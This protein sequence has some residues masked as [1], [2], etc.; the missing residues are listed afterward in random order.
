LPF[1]KTSFSE[2]RNQLY[3]SMLR[4]IAGYGCFTA[5]FQGARRTRGIQRCLSFKGREGEPLAR[6]W[7]PPDMHKPQRG[8]ARAV[9]V[10]LPRHSF[11]FCLVLKSQGSRPRGPFHFTRTAPRIASSPYAPAGNKFLPFTSGASEENHRWTQMNT[12]SEG[13]TPRVLLLALGRCP[14]NEFT[15]W[16]SAVLSS[17]YLC[18]SVSICGC[19]ELFR[20][21]QAEPGDLRR[22]SPTFPPTPPRKRARKPSKWRSSRDRCRN[23]RPRGRA[24]PADFWLPPSPARG[25]RVRHCRRE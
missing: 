19:I 13:E 2:T 23:S 5:G 7:R 8:Q 1:L 11:A 15:P 18:L 24:R 21:R 20:L 25:R 17:S 16:K 9:N 3:Y 22:S 4:R 6:C 14:A 12:D 10:A